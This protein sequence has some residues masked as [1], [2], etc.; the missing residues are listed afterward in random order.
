MDDTTPGAFLYGNE[1]AQLGRRAVEFNATGDADFA[2][3]I[4]VRG[5]ATFGSTVALAAD[6][7]TALQAATKQYVDNNGGATGGGLY[8]PSAYGLVALSADPMAVQGNSAVSAGDVWAVRMFIP[9]N[10][11]FSKIWTP[12]KTAGTWDGTTHPNQLGLYDDTGAKLDTTADDGT[13]WTATGWRGGSLLGGT[14]PAQTT[15]RYV[16]ILGLLRGITGCI[17]PFP[18][19]AQDPTSYAATGPAGGNVR[20]FYLNAQTALPAS[21]NPASVSHVT[22]FMILAGAS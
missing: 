22:G 18:S 14:Q 7:T 10:T 20:A 1:I 3:A 12:V 19:S 9:K 8:P 15:D 11:A 16:Y 4:D 21:F 5:A 17:L 13:L 6:P 2:G